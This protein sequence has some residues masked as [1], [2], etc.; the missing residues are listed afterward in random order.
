MKLVYRLDVSNFDLF[1]Q[2]LSD[3]TLNLKDLRGRMDMNSLRMVHTE[4]DI[5]KLVISILL[6]FN[7][8]NLEWRSKHIPTGNNDQLRL[9]Y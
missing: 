2:S 5:E 6:N 7:T 8:H 4:G 3:T 9:D 1:F